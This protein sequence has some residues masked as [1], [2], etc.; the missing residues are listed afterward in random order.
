VR[1]NGRELFGQYDTLLYPAVV[2]FCAGALLC[3]G[4]LEVRF[5]VTLVRL[6][7]DLPVDAFLKI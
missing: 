3:I 6:H 2:R 5:P 1:G 4:E 7:S